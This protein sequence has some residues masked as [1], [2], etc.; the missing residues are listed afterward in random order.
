VRQNVA[1]EKKAVLSLD[2]A[3]GE[4]RC[5][6]QPLHA[7][8]PERLYERR[9]VLTLLDLVLEQLRIELAE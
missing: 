5:Q 3:S 2:F 8:T 1:A 4:S 6:T 7:L 9:C